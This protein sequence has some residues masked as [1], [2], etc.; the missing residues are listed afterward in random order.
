M[1]IKITVCE[2]LRHLEKA[3]HVDCRSDACKTLSRSLTPDTADSP[4]TT[5]TV[6]TADSPSTADTAGTADTADTEDSPDTAD[7][8]RNKAYD[9]D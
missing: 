2:E 8:L 4:G 6:D 3:L 1:I 9:R 5:G 7:R